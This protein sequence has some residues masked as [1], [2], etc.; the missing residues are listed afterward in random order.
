LNAN[1]SFGGWAFNNQLPVQGGYHVW[2]VYGETLVP[3]LEN[4]PFAK[5]LEL[6]A[7]GRHTDY[8]LSGG[9]NTWKVGLSYE[10]FDSLRIRGTRS[11]DIRAP[12]LA[13]LFEGGGSAQAVVPDRVLGTNVQVFDFAVGNLKLKP[14]VAQ[15][16]TAG[17]I[18]QPRFVPGLSLSVDYYNI[19]IADAIS[20]LSPSLRVINCY[21]GVPH[22][23]D[24]VVFNPNG[25][26]AYIRH[27][28]ENLNALKTS[29][30][31]FELSYQRSLQQL[32]INLPGQL[33]LR[34]LG[35]YV[36]SLIQIDASG[37]LEKA[38]WLSLNNRI[39]G[40]PKFSGTAD[41]NYSN[42][43]WSLGLFG[44]LIGQGEYSTLLTEGT[45]AANTIN[46]N[47]I[48]AFFYLGL[49]AEYR[50]SIGN[51][52]VSLFGA[53]NNLMDTNPPLIPS[54]AVGGASETATNPVFY[55]VIGRS[56]KVGVRF[57]F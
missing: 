7:A 49:N 57:K 23:C 22:A 32:G 34:L 12:N 41:L 25:T 55:D 35:T 10:P 4:V 37:P 2:E 33:S 36:D 11:R 5:S 51:H 6:N 45:G 56:F 48:P 9:V 46:D 17:V 1:G 13:E 28:S 50:L 42:D 8:S 29:G 30:V 21:N 52:D 54:G 15:T 40:V 3:L 53:I 27:D 26:I 47:H 18:Y 31:D 44:K 14:E 16:W 20:S 38:G 43:R 19:K 24:S 39:T